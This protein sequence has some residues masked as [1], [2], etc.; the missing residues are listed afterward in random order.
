M[1]SRTTKILLISA[2]LGLSICQVAP[3]APEEP[4]NYE[5]CKED[6]K[7]P[8]DEPKIGCKE[9]K[10]TFT[11]K[12]TPVPDTTKTYHECKPCGEKC[13][14]CAWD[15]TG[16]KAGACSACIEKHGLDAADATKCKP[17]TDANCSECQV[18]SAKCAKCNTGFGLKA[19]ACEKCS[20]N[21]LE[22]ENKDKCTKC[23]PKFGL[24]ADKCEACPANCEECNDKGEC[25]KCS[26]GS[27]YLDA[28]TKKCNPCKTNCLSCKAGDT[29]EGCISGY[30]LYQNS[31]T[32]TCP[33]TMAAVNGI[34]ARCSKN[35]RSCDAYDTCRVCNEGFYAKNSQCVECP[36]GCASCSTGGRCLSCNAGT[37]L[38][39]DGTCS[40]TKWYQR[41]WV[42]LLVTLAAI[43]LLAACASMLGKAGNAGTRQYA[44]YQNYDGNTSYAARSQYEMNASQGN[45]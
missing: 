2:L 44:G 38:Q 1:I 40:T 7:L 18:D 3:P 20:E 35:C 31:C 41:W 15:A 6:Y 42:W 39:G 19:D 29:C 34:C 33:G 27:F 17:C 8:I 11:A 36:A 21:C 12:S 9:C 16:D 32:T 14:A 24:K 10:P 22:C 43:G 13:V 23:A 25:T 28:T 26:L 37:E 4:S 30:N 5:N 45:F